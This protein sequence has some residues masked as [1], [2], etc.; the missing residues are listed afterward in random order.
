MKSARPKRPR[1]EQAFVLDAYKRL[2]RQGVPSLWEAPILGRSVDLVYLAG[3]DLITI[4]FKLRDWKR[5]LQQARDH[6]IGADFSY[7]CLPG[8]PSEA[9]RQA[10]RAEGIGVLRFQDKEAWPFTIEEPASRSDR[11][12]RTLRDELRDRLKRRADKPYDPR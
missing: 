1:T 11:T 8:E 6:Q 4:E 9:F 7:V 3:D 2:R 12:W 5:G 10:A